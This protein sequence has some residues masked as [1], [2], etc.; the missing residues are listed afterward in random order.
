MK[1]AFFIVLLANILLFLW[2]YFEPVAN[3]PTQSALSNPEPKQLFLMSELSSTQ[4]ARLQPPALTNNSTTPPTPEPPSP[5]A[6]EQDI[7]SLSIINSLN[8]DFNL[9]HTLKAFMHHLPESIQTLSISQRNTVTATPDSTFILPRE[10]NIKNTPDKREA[11]P[12][13]KKNEPNPAAPSP[14]AQDYCYE[15]GP[16]SNKNAFTQW[17]NYFNLTVISSKAVTKMDSESG[18]YMVYMPAA[19]TAEQ[20]QQRLQL[21]ADNGITDI[22]KFTEGAQKGMLSLGI[23]QNYL[24]AL[25]FQQKLQLKNIATSIKKRLIDHPVT[26]TFAQIK[27][28]SPLQQDPSEA[29]LF[30][31]KALE[32]CQE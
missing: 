17:Q 24:S 15:V 21:L 14:I 28:A 22:W 23:F 25:Q 27:L 32:A 2:H 29:E 6:T 26:A 3:P 7:P 31:I 19:E 9:F 10:A 30:S 4:L 11:A 8:K 13:T 18:T 12:E 1:A 16:F 20:A 5:T